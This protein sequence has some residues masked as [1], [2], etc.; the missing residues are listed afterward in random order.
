MNDSHNCPYVYLAPVRQMLGLLLGLLLFLFVFTAYGVAA[1][2]NTLPINPASTRIDL[3]A[4]SWLLEDPEGKL[5]LAD[6]QHPDNASRFRHRL[7]H[8]G[9]TA[10]AWWV[11]LTLKSDASVPVTWWFDS[12]NRTLQEIALFVP[13]EQGV[14]QSQFASSKLPFANRPLPTDD[15]V[16]PV[17][18]FPQKSTEIYLRVRST[19]FLGVVIAPKLWQPKAY[20][21]HENSLTTQW[22][23]YLGMAAALGLF[24]LM[25]C[26]SIRDRN[27]LLYTA[28]LVAIAWSMS[29]SGGG[30]G[31]AY[32][33]FWPNYPLFEQAAWIASVFASAYFPFL[34]VFSFTN[35]RQNMPRMAVFIYICIV[36]TGVSI[37]A[38]LLS[39]IEVLPM[40]TQISQQISL[41]GTTVSGLMYAGI[42]ASLCHLAWRGNRQASF[43][44]I[45]WLPMLFCAT[46]WAQN[47]LIGKTF[48]IAFL[49]WSSAFELILMALALAD[50]FNQE[51]QSKELAQAAGVEILRRS[52]HEL[53]EKVALRT[54]E[55]QQEQTRTK[56][57]LHNILPADIAT[58]LSETGSAQSARHDAV[59]ILFTDFIGFTQ[60]ASLMPANQVV[61]ELNDIFAAFDD[62]A[63]TCG[64]EKIKTIGDA[65]M[66]V[67]GLP[68]PC[69]DHAQRCVR[70]ALL[71]VA[72]LERR[73]AEAT[74]KWFLRIGIHSGPVVAGVVG[75]RKFAFDIW[76]DAVNIA[77]RI[78][79]AGENGRV[80]VSACTYDLIRDDFKCQYR[81]K[82]EVKGKGL[83]DMYFV[84]EISLS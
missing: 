80:N 58:E 34:F 6:V 26:F 82:L 39:L 45:A 22:M 60:I 3:A 83:M 71:M 36:L 84:S 59:S 28:S 18:L 32:R 73:N 27:Y 46:I 20:M 77:A 9:Y 30:V 49:M 65:Y 81:G 54:L 68:K 53:E 7:P 43:L 44:C 2:E 15:F 13:D 51:K 72:Y 19:G 78:E 16:F 17:T 29:S 37:S 56:E 75:K 70:A 79:S 57:L 38:E 61:D 35:F 63:D 48:N 24:N 4:A 1:A 25:L 5:T 47:I 55:L 62:I 10:S 33:Y 11:R 23:F 8:I 40:T 67:A 76:G 66:A 52:E 42:A 74:F 69:A 12:H 64:L 50:R 21:A 41:A 31:S 14:M